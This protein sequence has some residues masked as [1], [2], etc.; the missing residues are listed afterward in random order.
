MASDTQQI[1][2][3]IINTGWPASPGSL[4]SLKTW[5]GPPFG[6]VFGGNGSV[7]GVQGIDISMREPD[8]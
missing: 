3:R 4:S 6:P 1:R 5:N 7:W 8:F 2:A